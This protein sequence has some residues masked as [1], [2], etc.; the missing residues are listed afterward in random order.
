MPKLDHKHLIVNAYVK[1][2]PKQ[3]DEKLVENWLHK[4]VNTIG[5]KT[6]I[7]PRAHYCLALENNGIT[8]SVN[9]E[10]SHCAMHVWD[11]A[12]P[13]VFNLDLYSCA[14]FDKTTV[15]ELLQDFDP[16]CFSWNLFDRND[17]IKSIDE[18][19]KQ[20]LKIIDLLSQDEKKIYLEA[21]KIIPQLRSKEHNAARAKYAG[22]RRKYSVHGITYSRRR[23]KTHIPTL[24]SI[25]ARAT[26]NHLPF[27]LDT[28]WYNAELEKS[29]AKWLRIKEHPAGNRDHD[30]WSAQVDRIV[31]EK[32]YVK[33]NCRI[34]PHAL[35]IAK[36][37]WN[38]SELE[39]LTELLKEEISQHP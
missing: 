15:F 28:D 31:P 3:G 7:E 1:K 14:C 33:E 9:I 10:T 13:A 23:I 11:Q 6:V 8:A 32:G 21:Q 22:L 38:R 34:I 19:C 39:T 27:D 2:P 17:G 37:K 29:K 20:V 12:D 26:K 25:K 35:N 5:M 24:N 36:W 18:G 16:Y 4:L 30:F